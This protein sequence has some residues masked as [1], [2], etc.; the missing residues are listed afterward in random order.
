MREMIKAA[1]RQTLAECWLLK[2]NPAPKK[3]YCD[4][5]EPEHDDEEE[6]DG[7]PA[8]SREGALGGCSTL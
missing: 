2:G 7:E 3:E 5:K 8:C 6:G 1:R 4:V